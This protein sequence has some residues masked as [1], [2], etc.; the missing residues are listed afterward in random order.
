[1]IDAN[2]PSQLCHNSIHQQQICSQIDSHQDYTDKVR[3]KI[4]LKTSHSYAKV[5]PDLLN[6]DFS[7]P[8]RLSEDLS[9][10]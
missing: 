2:L 8:H 7:I 4:L 9:I 6:I 3:T 5:S 10:H 1:M